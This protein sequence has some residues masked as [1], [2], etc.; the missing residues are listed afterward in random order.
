MLKRKIIFKID[1]QKSSQEE[2]SF[3]KPHT[4]SYK[5]TFISE[6]VILLIKAFSFRN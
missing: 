1:D 6:L 3:H 2:L 5:N 4:Y